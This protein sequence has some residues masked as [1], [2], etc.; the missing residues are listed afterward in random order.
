MEEFREKEKD[1]KPDD[2]MCQSNMI[3]HREKKGKS[4]M[5]LKA[6][7]EQKRW[8]VTWKE[9]GGI[10]RRKGYN[11]MKSDRQSTVLA[12]VKNIFIF[13]NGWNLD[14]VVSDW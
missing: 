1:R 13:K 2:D 11:Y 4:G 5:A 10:A 8:R 12:K 7:F 3:H 14:S 6:N 9:F